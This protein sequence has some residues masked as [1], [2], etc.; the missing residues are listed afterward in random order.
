MAKYEKRIHIHKICRLLLFNLGILTL[1]QSD[2]DSIFEIPN[3]VIK[4][5]Y[6][7][8]LNELQQRESGYYIDTRDQMLAFKEIG[9]TGKVTALTKIVEEILLHT[10]NQMDI[11]SA[12]LPQNIHIN[13]KILPWIF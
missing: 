13:Q 8:Y 4:R 2:Y 9:R 12:K 10:S 7:Q 1:K 5:I 3:T 6:L 11:L